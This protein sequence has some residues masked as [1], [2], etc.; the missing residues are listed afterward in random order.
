VT[1]LRL[2]RGIAEDYPLKFK[3]ELKRNLDNFRFHV[4]AAGLT[5]DYAGLISE[6]FTMAQWALQSDAAEAVAQMSA[7]FANG[8][9]VLADIV[10][11][12]QDLIWQLQAAEERVISA[13]GK[14]DAGSSDAARQGI[15]T[16]E[17][18]LREL[19]QRLTKDFPSYVD[20]AITK[21]LSVATA[22]EALSDDEALV[23]F[24]NV[25]EYGKL[26][27][28]SF[29]WVLS[30]N[31]SRWLK[32]SL[33]PSEI[34]LEIARLRCGLDVS[35][36][37][38]QAG[39]NR[40]NQCLQLLSLHSPPARGEPLPFDVPTAFKLYAALFGS[41][42]DL[43]KDKKLIVVPSGALTALPFSVLVTVPPDSNIVGFEAYRK[44][45]WFGLRQPITVLPSIASLAG[46]R[47]Y[48]RSSGATNTYIGFGDPLLV[49]RLGGDR[50]AWDAQHC[51]MLNT[52]VPLSR[53]TE[54]PTALND[55][56]G[57]WRGSVID[58]NLLRLLPPLPETTREVCTVARRSGVPE[59]QLESRVWLG[60]R[61]TES[62]V[63]DL[64]RRGEL[65]AYSIVHFA[66]HGLTAGDLKNLGQP[67]LVLTPP[68]QGNEIDDGL[69]TASE[70]AELKLNADWVVLSACNS[71]SGSTQ[72]AEA[73]SGLAKAFFHAGARAL[74][75]SHWQ[76]NSDA[77]VKLST[78]TFDAL[79]NNPTIG[80]AEALQKAMFQMA[81][82]DSLLE[83]HPS[84][85]GPFVV[86]G[87]GSRGAGSVSGR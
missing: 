68:K 71:A 11:E 22:Q 41:V 70:I 44:A 83:T 37:S 75:L 38:G 48:A 82:S 31:Y 42:E 8:R 86:V 19:D 28:A 73:L 14:F 62:N 13:A 78:V 25:P 3:P 67:G 35:V 23:A 74:L 69:L 45:N 85:W 47:K 34:E 20:L 57:A 12:R 36:W 64:S 84:V 49:G 66:T 1:A 17:A 30:K 32:L 24:L 77:A 50:R 46:L 60:E 81:N 33:K 9:G 80:R 54:E 72:S 6:S 4:L 59:S 76:I 21:P 18:K 40:A 27:E 87:E 15:I 7:R 43:I 55:L 26:D 16:L 65:S 63:K 39:L 56:N 10:R 79:R 2:I 53:A 51:P 5:E 58:V 29:A 52:A 61:A